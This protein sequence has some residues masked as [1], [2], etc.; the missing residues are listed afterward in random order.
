MTAVE[1]EHLVEKNYGYMRAVAWRKLR[2][3]DEAEEAV[4]RAILNLWGRHEKL[5]ASESRAAASTLLIKATLAAVVD[6]VRAR[7]GTRR[8]LRAAGVRPRM[9]SHEEQRP[10]S[11][12][13]QTAQVGAGGCAPARSGR[14]S[15]CLTAS[16][17]KTWLD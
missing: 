12:S 2:K 3:W 17:R 16:H 10:A 8:T 6:M 1:F 9:S 13:R 4:Q 5:D 15:S 14:P 7:V 11:T